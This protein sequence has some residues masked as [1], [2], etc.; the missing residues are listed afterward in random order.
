MRRSSVSA[1][2]LR[3][4]RRSSVGGGAASSLLRAALLNEGCRVARWWVRRISV[5]SAL[6]SNPAQHLNLGPG[7][8]R[9]IIYP[10]AG[11]YTQLRMIRS[12]KISTRGWIPCINVCKI[13]N[14]YKKECRKRHLNF[15][16]YFLQTVYQNWRGTWDVRNKI[17]N[18]MSKVSFTSGFAYNCGR[19]RRRQSRQTHRHLLFPS[20]HASCRQYMNWIFF[21]IALAPFQLF[22]YVSIALFGTD[23]VLNNTYKLPYNAYLIFFQCFLAVSQSTMEWVDQ[24]YRNK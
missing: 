22:Y 5:V 11:V 10:D 6:G 9:W 20:V 12:K 3:W 7:P 8:T 18:S 2:Q 23:T 16:A 14:K 15:K 19:S 13:Q 17:L 24:R 4:V 1:E 21:A